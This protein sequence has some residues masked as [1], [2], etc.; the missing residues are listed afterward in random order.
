L[1]YFEP[2]K[3]YFENGLFI[4]EYDCVKRNEEQL[5]KEKVEK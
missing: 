2:D 4:K 5:K 3:I 1:G